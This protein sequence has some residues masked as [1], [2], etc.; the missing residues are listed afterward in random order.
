MCYPCP[1]W[2]SG[3]TVDI[4]TAEALIS[5]FSQELSGCTIQANEDL[6]S[7]F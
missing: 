2:A 7:T 4:D 1:T 6:T 3:C 5:G